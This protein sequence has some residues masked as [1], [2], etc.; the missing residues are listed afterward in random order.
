MNTILKIIS[1]F[2]FCFLVLG[3]CP[4][5][6]QN[7]SSKN[8]KAIKHYEEAIKFYDG[9]NLTAC[10]EELKKASEEDPAF[11]EPHIMLGYVYGDLNQ[12]PK[13]IEEMKAAIGINPN[14]YWVNYFTLAKLQFG[15]GLYE[16]AKKNFDKYLEKPGENKEINDLAKR[17]IIN[18]DFA[19]NAL[20]HPVPFKPVNEGPGLNSKYDEYYPSI[21]ADEQTFLFTRRVPRKDG[22]G[23]QED[24]YVCNKQDGKWGN[25]YGIGPKINTEGNEGAPCLSADGEIL[26][27]VACEGDF[28]Y[29]A[30]RTGYGSCDIFYALKNGIDW[31]KPKNVGA[32]VNT[33]WWESQPSFASDGKT[34]YFVR[35]TVDANGKKVQDIYSSVLKDDGKWS[36]PKKLSDKI[37][38][39]YNE[40]SVFIHPDNQTL[41]FSSD[42]HPGMGG[43]DI[44]MSRRQPDGEWGEAINLGYPINTFND[45]NSLLVSRDGKT[46]W[47]ASDRAGGYGGL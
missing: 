1:L 4:A 44:F 5:Q 29:G 3:E 40:E 35:G 42:G 31:T 12:N 26:F 14:F 20:A 33:K 24:F 39:P 16:D 25:A 27:F 23:L 17:D 37:N 38:T 43:L 22:T 2:F 32:P 34:L 19:I 8:K 36:N 9:R 13:A 28:G 46:G 47:F 41:Y 11:I 7:Y 18:C 30:D 15:S 21:T 6:Q 10:V 45:E